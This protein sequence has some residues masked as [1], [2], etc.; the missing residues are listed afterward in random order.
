M[1]TLAHLKG[2][3]NSYFHVHPL[4]TTFSLITA[5]LLAVA[6]VLMLASSAR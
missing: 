1:K 4:H 6:I 5:F 2:H 3:G